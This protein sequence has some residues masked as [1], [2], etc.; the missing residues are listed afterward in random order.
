MKRSK[1]QKFNFSHAR[2]CFFTIL[3]YP[4]CRGADR[5]QL[6]SDGAQRARS[7]HKVFLQFGDDVFAVRVLP[8]GIQMRSDFVHQHFALCRL[9][10]VDHLL[11]DVIRVLVL[12]HDVQS[13]VKEN[14]MQ[15]IKKKQLFI[16]VVDE[17][18]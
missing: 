9:A 3:E 4:V 1:M 12:H 6:P 7:F 8:Q 18:F 14:A 16:G 2:R 11:D 15:F 10:D 17:K 5:A 13:A